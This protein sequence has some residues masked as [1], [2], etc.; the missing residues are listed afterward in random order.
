MRIAPGRNAGLQFHGDVGFPDQRLS[1][2]TYENLGT[3]RSLMPPDHS[4]ILERY[5][6]ATQDPPA[7]AAVLAEIHRRVRGGSE[8]RLLREDFAGNG[9]DAVAWVAG[10]SGR[11][12]LTVDADAV[13][14]AHGQQ[15][16]L[17][18]LGRRAR[19]IDWHVAD[20]HA[21]APPMVQ[22]ADLMSVLNFSI[23]YLHTRTAL[24][25]YLEH[26]RRALDEHGVLVLNTFGGP[27]ALAAHTDRH[28]VVP[29]PD[30]T[31][32]PFDYL[33]ETRRFDA[34]SARIDCR[35]H[36]EW[37]DAAVPGGVRRVDDAFRY[38]WRLWTLPEL[39]EALREAGF[40]RA[41]VWRHT[42]REGRNGPRVFLGPVRSLRN[43]RIW[44]AYVVGIV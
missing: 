10:G 17:R 27:D 30:S 13:T 41:Q 37:P 16:A 36:F 8:A 23:G 43:R 40:S 20:V 19:C 6:W 18:L 12:A 2:F 15:R 35:I 1:T 44:V 3:Q 33:W 4:E 29:G 31:L 22:R 39:T 21:V 5:R 32:A 28:A 34:C 7:Q 11:R 26:A 9:A 38:D 24:R 14:V 25:R 42:A